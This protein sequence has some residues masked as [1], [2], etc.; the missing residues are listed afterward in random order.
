MYWV[1]RMPICARISLRLALLLYKFSIIYIPQNSLAFAV[2]KQGGYV[3]I[4]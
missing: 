3:E 4:W 2:F 1:V